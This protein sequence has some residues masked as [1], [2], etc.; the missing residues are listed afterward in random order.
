M[1]PTDSRQPRPTIHHHISTRPISA[2]LSPSSF[3]TRITHS[4]GSSDSTSGGVDLAD[5]SHPSD[6]TPRNSPGAST[7]SNV[8]TQTEG[9]SNISQTPRTP[10]TPLPPVTGES[11]RSTTLDGRD[12]PPNPPPSPAGDGSAAGPARTRRL[13]RGGRIRASQTAVAAFN[14]YFG[15]ENDLAN[16]QRLCRNVR[17]EVIP[18]S[19]AEC[20]KVWFYASSSSSSSCPRVLSC[21]VFIPLF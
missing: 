11:C 16:W 12:P 20:K 2:H 17:I 19:I 9:I 7:S 3:S 5:Q 15:D 8:E 10:Q 13:R 14:T 4:S 1:K 21:V 6:P 18:E